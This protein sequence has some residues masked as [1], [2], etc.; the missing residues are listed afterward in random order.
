VAK[1]LI[2]ANHEKP[3]PFVW[4][5]KVEEI[6]EKA[7]RCKADVGYTTLDINLPTV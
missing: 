4:A 6:L 2:R 5:K 7:A 1:E 3:T